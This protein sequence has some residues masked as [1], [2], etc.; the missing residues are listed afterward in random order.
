[1]LAP[2]IGKKWLFLAAAG[3]KS[4]GLLALSPSS[5]LHVSLST[6]IAR[7][8]QLQVLIKSHDLVLA[9]KSRSENSEG[10]QLA[11]ITVSM[12]KVHGV[13]DRDCLNVS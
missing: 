13:N 7:V 3:R 4:Y 2:S 8:A 1:M 5:F 12:M 10:T 11:E 9:Y 6:P